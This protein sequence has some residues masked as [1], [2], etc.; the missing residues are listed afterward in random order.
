MPTERSSNRR[1]VLDVKSLRI[2]YETPKGDVIAVADIDLTLEEGETLGLV[3]ESGCGKST[4]AMGILQL[5]Q[6][7]GRI[8]NGQVVLDGDDVLKLSND[9]LRRLRWEEDLAHPTGRDELP[10]PGDA[11]QGS[12]RRRHPDPRGSASKAKRAS[13]SWGCCAWWASQV[14]ST[15]CIPTS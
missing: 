11:R 8:V 9:D 5:V 10:Q 14:G 15:T 6:P 12:D 13:A 3:G 1:V 7:P 2:H 4:A